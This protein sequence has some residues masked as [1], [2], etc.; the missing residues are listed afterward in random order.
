MQRLNEGRK[1]QHEQGKSRQEDAG[2]SL[3]QIR[4]LSMDRERKGWNKGA[5]RR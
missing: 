3:F 4:H 2:E 1:Q 5:Q